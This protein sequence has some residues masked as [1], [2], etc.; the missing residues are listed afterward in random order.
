M[1]RVQWRR[2]FSIIKLRSAISRYMAPEVLD[3][4]I[5]MKHFESFKRADIYAMGLVFWEIASRCSVGGIHEDYQL[6]YY[7]LV[8]SD[9]SVEE[10]RK[11]VCE[12]KLRP[13]IPNRWQS[14]E[15][16]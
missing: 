8:Q 14:C 12:Q 7:D 4:S 16:G 10:M 11:V 6:P 5:N 15:V 9:P 3:D 2:R 1:A 13:N